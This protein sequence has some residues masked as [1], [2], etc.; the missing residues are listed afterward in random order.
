MDKGGNKINL[1]IRE[2]KHK[3]TDF[4]RE[5]LYL[6]LYVPKGQSPFPKSILDNPDISKYIDHWDTLPNDIALVAIFNEELIGAIWGRTFS[7]SNAGYGFIDENTPEICMAVKEKF[8][9]Q[10]IGAKLIDEISKIYFSKGI[11]S[12]SLS[13][14]KQNRAKL[15]YLRTGFIIVEDEGVDFTMKKIL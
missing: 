14:D 2:I 13:V 12:I 3:E 10:G 15:L 8:R 4:L 1:I 7:R 9:N 5:I 11:K 6:A